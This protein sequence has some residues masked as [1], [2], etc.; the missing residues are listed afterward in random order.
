M[1]FIGRFAETLMNE[2][3]V[4]KMNTIDILNEIRSPALLELE[5]SGDEIKYVRQ[6][7][8]FKCKKTKLFLRYI[9]FTLQATF[10]QI[11]TDGQTSKCQSLAIQ[12]L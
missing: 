1:F 3:V 8:G 10:D 9:F 4:L 5:A 2:Q 11:E 12:C 6:H 7:Q